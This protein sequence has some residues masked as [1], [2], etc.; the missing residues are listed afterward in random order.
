MIDVQAGTRTLVV[1]QHAERARNQR[2]LHGWGTR[3][4][5]CYWLAR[6]FWIDPRVGWLARSLGIY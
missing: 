6:G 4:W 5:F 1:R 3:L 2:T